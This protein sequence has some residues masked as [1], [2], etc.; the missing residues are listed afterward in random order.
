MVRNMRISVFIDPS[1]YA[2]WKNYAAESKLSYK[3]DSEL[4]R[5]LIHRVQHAEKLDLDVYILRDKVKQLKERLL[6]REDIISKLQSTRVHLQQDLD[7]LE[8][9]IKRRKKK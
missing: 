1:E 7:R 9:N 4:V 6:Q 5:N 3:N 8:E 2:N